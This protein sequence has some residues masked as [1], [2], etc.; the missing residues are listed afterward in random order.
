M[1]NKIVTD[2]VSEGVHVTLALRS[3]VRRCVIAALEYEGMQGCLVLVHFSDDK[4]IHGLNLEY[5]DVDRATDVLSF[6]FIELQPGE[7]PEPTPENTDMHGRVMLG[8][9][10]IS[11]ERAEAQAAEYGHSLEREA[12]FLAVHSTLHLLGYDHERGAEAE[13]AQFMLQE[14]I[15]QSMGLTRDGN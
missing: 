3:V 8:E 15:L 14:Q 5:R 10:I 12:G 6:P 13:H 4:F 9:M 1:R 2:T 11:L 7:Q